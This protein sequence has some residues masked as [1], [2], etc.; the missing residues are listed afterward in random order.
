MAEANGGRVAARM[1]LDLAS[2]TIV[3]ERYRL[4]HPLGQ[5]GMGFVW[6][7][8]H[9]V[10]RRSVAMKFLRGPLCA[11]ADMRQ[12]FLREGRAASAVDHPN[13]VEVYD[14]LELDET[15]PVMVM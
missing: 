12:R 5:G 7:A 4:D 8:T 15:T 11:R 9:L 13:V 3:A 6:Q 1:G 2:G 14:V 10:T